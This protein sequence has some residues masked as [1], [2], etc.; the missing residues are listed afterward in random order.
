M[1]HRIPDFGHPDAPRFTHYF[2]MVVLR[3]RSYLRREWCLRVVD[4]PL[5][6]ER[7][8]DGRWRHW[9]VVPEL[10]G[11]YL[12]VVTLEDGWTIHNAFPDRGFLL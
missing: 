9:G 1:I 8:S 2:E 5:R 6:I 7:Q 4:A 12:R 10:G 11:R 3:K